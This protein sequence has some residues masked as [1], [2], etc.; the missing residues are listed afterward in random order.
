[1]EW[2]SF[3]PRTANTRVALVVM[4]WIGISVGQQKCLDKDFLPRLFTLLKRLAVF[5]LGCF[6]LQERILWTHPLVRVNRLVLISFTAWVVQHFFNAKQNKTQQ[7][8][9]QKLKK[10][11][12]RMRSERFP[13]R[14]CASKSQAVGLERLNC[15]IHSIIWLQRKATVSAVA[16]QMTLG[17]WVKKK[18]FF[19]RF[20][21]ALNTAHRC[22]LNFCLAFDLIAAYLAQDPVRSGCA[23]LAATCAG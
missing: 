5:H 17:W 12:I 13:Y 20:L 7:K 14:Y 18:S 22:C 6:D 9:V 21:G 8:K 11:N 23:T 15:S 1:M 3:I 19:R 10:K 4:S 16:N 2:T